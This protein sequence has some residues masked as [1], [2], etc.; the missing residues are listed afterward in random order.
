MLESNS[1]RPHEVQPAKLLCLW[2]LTGKNTGMS[3]LSFLQGILPI[4]GSN[5]GLLH[6]RQILYHRSHQG[7]LEDSVNRV[8]IPVMLNDLG[9]NPSG[10]WSCMVE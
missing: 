2:N 9:I 5:L 1:S 8:L 4:L 6:C 10:S 3:C 7:N